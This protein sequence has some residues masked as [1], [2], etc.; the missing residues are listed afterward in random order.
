M[1]GQELVAI[2]LGLFFGFLAVSKFFGKSVVKQ[3]NDHGPQCQEVQRGGLP[4]ENEPPFLPSWYEVLG[5]SA[6]ASLEEI[7]SAHKSLLDKYHPDK[8]ESMGPEV[9]AICE[10][11]S[12]EI[13]NAY[14]K[15]LK[16]RGF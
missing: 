5:V 1:S 15:A 13:N 2:L 3:K 4:N 10:A 9:K 16:A 12:K 14:E 6:S 8:V 7:R 11:R